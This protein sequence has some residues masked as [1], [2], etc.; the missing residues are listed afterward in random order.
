METSI[1]STPDR[2]AAVLFGKSM[3]AILALL[4]GRSDRRFFMREIARAAGAPPSSL[5]RDLSSLA[6]AGVLTRVGEGRQ[7]YYQANPACPIYGELKSIAAKTFG[8][9]G[10][11]KKLLA[12]HASRLKLA[13]VYG[14]VA[15]GSAAAASDIDLLWV[16]RLSPSDL[17]LDMAKAEQRLARKISVIA[18][19]EDEFAGLL[20]EG[21]SFLSSVLAGPV[22]WLIGNREALD[23]F[24]QAQPRKPRARKAAQR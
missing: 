3:R 21:G 13:F 15:K 9:A 4:Y 20:A 2:L 22:L 12:P 7:V 23:E 19:D 1:A 8:V 18:Y 17:V 6:G 24:R 16:G 11:L 14:S 5:Q 10:E